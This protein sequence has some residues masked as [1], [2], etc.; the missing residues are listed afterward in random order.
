M[1]DKAKS[2]PDNK[3]QPKQRKVV[4]T[5]FI[6]LSYDSDSRDLEN[7]RM[8]ARELGKAIIAMHDLIEKSDKLLN[9]GRRKSLGVFVET[10]AQEGS[11]EVVFGI[12]IYNMT[13][14]VIDVLP[15]IGLGY[16]SVKS[17]KSVFNLG[18]TIF[19]AINDTKGETVIGIHTNDN[20]DVA[21][22]S[23]DGK[24][25]KSD[26]NIAKLLANKDIR[27]NIKTLVS[28]PLEGNIK[29]AFK[30]LA[31]NS[32]KT[33]DSSEYSREI[34]V[35]LE[36]EEIRTIQ[37][38]KINDPKER[39]EI[40]E[41]TIALL[42]VSFKGSKGWEMTYGNHSYPV[43]ITDEDFIKKINENIA[44]FK[45]GDLFTVT[46]N[47]TIKMLGYETKEYYTITKVKHHLAP[48]ERRIISDN[49]K[50]N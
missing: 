14:Q 25:I 19:D 10:P 46:M 39:V 12:D 48:E 34:L 15:Y 35:K 1:T 16:A 18:K 27:E 5:E 49:G 17:R 23:V 21:T 22:L 36:P 45:K 20:S 2:L 43:E 41:T 13:T 40:L 6:T 31:G 24:E 37:K 9:P 7:H 3:K 38:M 29:P 4:R 42:T 44:S 26:K 50:I 32:I 11:L 30:I 28:S 8:N 47:K 33:P